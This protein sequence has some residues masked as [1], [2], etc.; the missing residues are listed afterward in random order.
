MSDSPRPRAKSGLSVMRTVAEGLMSSP[1]LGSKALWANCVPVWW[2][3][4]PL[5]YGLPVY[6][7]IPGAKFWMDS[8]ASKELTALP[9]MLRLKTSLGSGSSCWEKSRIM[10]CPF[11]EVDEDVNC[12]GAVVAIEEV[13]IAW[14]KDCMKL[15]DSSTSAE[16]APGPSSWSWSGF[17]LTGRK[18]SEY[19][20]RDWRLYD[21]VRLWFLYASWLSRRICR[22]VFSL[23]SG[24]NADDVESVYSLGLM[25]L[26]SMVMFRA[27]LRSS[28]STG[29]R[30][31][32][33]SLNKSSMLL[34]PSL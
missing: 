32:R 22:I 10:D 26:P 34:S 20:G 23:P 5:T 17:E 6:G 12:A 7:L 21:R 18:L 25:E 2:L 19:S 28:N 16:G 33:R 27:C 11:V 29:P 9:L 31:C 24:S 13:S 30:G 8:M 3:I 14:M 4:S 15:P 1:V